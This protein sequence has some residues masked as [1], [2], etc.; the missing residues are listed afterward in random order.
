[1]TAPVSSTRIQ[2][3]DLPLRLFHWLLAAAVAV[4]FISAKVGGNAMVWHGRAGL[5]VI[6]LIVFRIIWGFI[7]STHARFANFVRGPSA[8]R[9]YLRGEWN[10]L[11][12]NPLGA[13]SVLVLIT[14][15]ALE[16]TTGLFAN[17]DISYQG[18]LYALVGADLSSRLT[19]IH[20]LFE[21]AMIGLVAL[22]LAA[23]AY[24]LRVKKHN[25]AIPMVTGWKEVS[26][27][28]IA[29]ADSARGGGLVAFVV[30]LLIGIAAAYAASGALLPPP[31]PAAAVETP[32]F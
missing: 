28:T 6:G 15:F 26:D 3:W 30:A 17:D 20:K 8:I 32:N 16:A 13:L 10:G 4:A 24:Y 18:Y 5:A 14:L 21:P 12:H 11:G 23:I 31:A 7:G 29:T 1:M 22:H 2:V 19:G 25:L 27:P 9:A